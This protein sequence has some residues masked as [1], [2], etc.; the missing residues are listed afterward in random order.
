MLTE[1]QIKG[2][3]KLLVILESQAT[4]KAYREMKDAREEHKKDSFIQLIKE[5][6]RQNDK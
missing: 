4:I 2:L 3:N 5:I 6:I 1:A